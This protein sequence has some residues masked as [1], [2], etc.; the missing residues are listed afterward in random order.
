M[1]PTPYEA[2]RPSSGWASIQSKPVKKDNPSVLK[3]SKPLKTKKN[4]INPNSA[5]EDKPPAVTTP[6]NTLSE[7]LGVVVICLGAGVDFGA[8]MVV[9]TG[10]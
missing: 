5:S 8:A 10:R 1:A 2:A 3:V 7:N 4:A 6:R 9:L